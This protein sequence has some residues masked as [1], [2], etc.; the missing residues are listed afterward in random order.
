M[1]P[2]V[3]QSEI[4]KNASLENNSESNSD[5]VEQLRRILSR[6][7][8]RLVNYDEAQEVGNSLIDFYQILAEEVSSG[9]AY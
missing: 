5:S 1:S 4:T 8:Q 3:A 6:Q 7:Q 9:P 2:R